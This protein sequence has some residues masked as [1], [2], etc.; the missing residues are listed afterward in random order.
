MT[1]GRSK[2]AKAEAHN[3]K[4]QAESAKKAPPPVENTDLPPRNSSDSTKARMP[5][6]VVKDDPSP[7]SPPSPWINSLRKAHERFLKIR[8]NPREIA[9]G[10]ALGIFIG[11]SPF[12]GIH[13]A[14]AVFLAALLKWNKIAAA[15][16]V[17]ISNP[18]S[19][20][21]IY[22][23]TYVV[24]SRFVAHQQSYPMPG[25][26]DLDALIALIKMGPEL[27]WV[28]VVGGIIVGIP[29]S[30]IAYFMAYGA[31]VEYRKTIRQKIVKSTKTIKSKLHPP[32]RPRRKNRKGRKKKNKR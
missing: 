3:I 16:A 9:L 6:H 7:G 5:L 15:I 8:G 28:L 12:M 32:R 20:P 25:T 1:D 14:A 18:L 21:L 22:G 23:L 13:T 11:M 31:I 19:A 4:F 17:W 26:F 24:G 30:V 10:F 29:L 2:P 27:L